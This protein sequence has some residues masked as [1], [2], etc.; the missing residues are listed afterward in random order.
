MITLVDALQRRL[1]LRSQKPLEMLKLMFNAWLD[2]KVDPIEVYHM[3]PI[4]AQKSLIGP[5][6]KPESLDVPYPML[7]LWIDYVVEYRNKGNDFSDDQVINML[8]GEGQSEVELVS[9]F[10][11]PRRSPKMKETADLLQKK[12]A[13]RSSAPSITCGHLI[14]AW[15]KSAVSL[16]DAYHMMPISSE[17]SSWVAAEEESSTPASYQMLELWIDY[18]YKYPSA[19]PSP[20]D[21]R[22]IEVLLADK[23]PE[24]ELVNFF[25]WLRGRPNTKERADLLQKKLALRSMTPLKTLQ[26]MFGVWRKSNV[27]FEDAYHMI[28][29]SAEKSFRD[30]VATTSSWPARFSKLQ[31]WI[32]Y[33]F[34]S[35]NL[36]TDYGRVIAVLLADKWPVE[37]LVSFFNRLRGTPDMTK[38]ADLLQKELGLKVPTSNTLNLMIHAW[39]D[40]G[41]SPDQVYHMM[42]PPAVKS[43]RDALAVVPDLPASFMNRELWI[44]YVVEYRNKGNDFSDDQVIN[45]L[46][47]EGLSEVELVSLFNWLRRSPKMKETAD[48]LQK[49]LALRSPDPLIT[50][51][52][53]IDAWKKSAVSLEDAYHMMPIPATKSSD[54]AAGEKSIWLAN[55]NVLQHWLRYASK[56]KSKV[57]EYQVIK[58]LVADN[59]NTKETKPIFSQTSTSR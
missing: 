24:E 14:D 34:E 20:W 23:R 5:I 50:C 42:P 27:D 21:D 13:L 35:G 12:L 33:V 54:R 3:M 9:L 18:G 44:G 31:L 52:H 55:F 40:A 45:M 11:W 49:K 48:L 38:T 16:E 19:S 43:F 57:D 1:V 51:G 10:N 6:E 41:V 58:L 59:M 47:G 37:E 25:N 30:V 28:S 26:L 46:V 36:N 53:L 2:F 4:P 15:K 22:V 56:S 17:K 29:I 39:T 8:V 7:G 32:E